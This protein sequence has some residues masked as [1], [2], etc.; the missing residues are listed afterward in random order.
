MSDGHVSDLSGVITDHRDV[1]LHVSDREYDLSGDGSHRLSLRVYCCR[2]V[3]NV[4]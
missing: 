2:H 3:E 4:R 1:R